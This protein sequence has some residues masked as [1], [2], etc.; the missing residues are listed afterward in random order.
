VVYSSEYHPNERHT[1][2]KIKA[3]ATHHTGVSVSEYT[4]PK[5]RNL[6]TSYNKLGKLYEMHAEIAQAQRSRDWDNFDLGYDEWVS[7]WAVEKS[8]VVAAIRAIMV[9]KDL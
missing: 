1:M 5:K 3:L 9:A 4:L 8:R 2:W 7:A 6:P